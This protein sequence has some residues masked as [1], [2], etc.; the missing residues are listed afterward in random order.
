MASLALYQQPGK[1]RPPA[2]GSFPIDHLGECTAL[3]KSYLACL[4]RRPLADVAGAGREASGSVSEAFAEAENRK[5]DHLPCRKF[6]QEYLQCR[7]QHNLMAPED[8]SALG[9]K[10]SRKEENALC[11]DGAAAPSAAALALDFHPPSSDGSCCAPSPAPGAPAPR[12]YPVLTFT[13]SLLQP[14]LAARPRSEAPPSGL[15]PAGPGDGLSPRSGRGGGRGGGEAPAEEKKE[16]KKPRVLTKED[17]G[18][19]AGCGALRP[20]TERGFFGRILSRYS[21]SN[22]FF[23]ALC[24]NVQTALASPEK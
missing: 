14:D 13:R 8:L 5:W 19:V 22:G 3:E 23:K 10:K 2:K 17:E 1:P 7:M 9:F 4:A 21:W 6:A 11:S 20:Y 12:S 24:E 18:F 15:Q 16:K